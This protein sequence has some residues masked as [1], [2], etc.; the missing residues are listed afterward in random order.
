MAQESWICPVE[1]CGK[2]ITVHKRTRQGLH[3]TLM[4]C[5]ANHRRAH[6]R[7]WAADPSINYVIRGAMN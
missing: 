3:M 1:G 2:I 6:E 5:V 7:K 4:A